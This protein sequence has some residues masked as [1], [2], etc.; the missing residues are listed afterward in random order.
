MAD[1]SK[2]LFL[3]LTESFTPSL[4]ET[5]SIRIKVNAL[6]EE[7][8]EKR[9]VERDK[10]ISKQLWK[11]TAAP[12]SEH[13]EQQGTISGGRVSTERSRRMPKDKGTN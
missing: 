5:D 2:E 4:E 3:E 1:K 8:A 10:A 9:R 7:R 13:K 6:M 11:E 12:S